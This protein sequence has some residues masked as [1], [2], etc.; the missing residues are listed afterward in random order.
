MSLKRVDELR[1]D[2]SD[3]ELLPS[4]T[5]A[6]NAWPRARS[7][8]RRSDTEED[9][10]PKIKRSRTRQTSRLSELIKMLAS[11]E[12]WGNGRMQD[13]QEF[14]Q[15]ILDIP[16]LHTSIADTIGFQLATRTYCRDGRGEIDISSHDERSVGANM[17]HLALDEH[18]EPK[19]MQ[20]LLDRNMQEQRAERPLQKEACRDA[21]KTSY[22]KHEIRLVKSFVVVA[23]KRFKGERNVGKDGF[24]N[25]VSVKLN[26]PIAQPLDPIVVA[27]RRMVPVAAIIHTGKSSSSGHYV[28]IA[29]ENDGNWYEY[30]DTSRKPLTAAA[31]SSRVKN[32]YV[33]LLRDAAVRDQ[34]A[35]APAFVSLPNRGNTCYQ[36]AAVQF[37]RQTPVTGLSYI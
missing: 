35:P 9:D 24:V 23:I 16:A 12:R 25:F 18:G 4:E 13:A 2:V 31:V 14:T 21:G 11:R 34:D 7:A 37:M 19:T 17:I 8:S 15:D 20:Q 30:D 22:I 32:A 33:L 6:W 1:I 28:T 5:L 3:A 26:T 10:S 27:E 29:R 36:N